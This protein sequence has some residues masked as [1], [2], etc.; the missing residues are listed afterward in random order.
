[1]AEAGLAANT[2]T[3][4]ILLKSCAATENVDE[5]RRLAA[6]MAEA[7]IEL[8]PNCAECYVPLLARS[9]GVGAGE[10]RAAYDSI[11]GKPTLKLVNEVMRHLASRGMEE[12]TIEYFS[13]MSRH[14]LDPTCA[15]FEPLVE[16]FCRK[17][18]MHRVHVLFQELRRRGIK[19]S[20]KVYHDVLRA[21]ARLGT[22]SPLM[23]HYWGELFKDK[24]TH[25]HT[26]ST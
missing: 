24:V 4:S 13:D 22:D 15:S 21:S 3:F 25:T 20:T 5:A 2:W 10:I 12:E 14:D 1:M 23:M 7:S 19:P 11:K 17:S 26:H 18:E 16:V 6:I 9:R 8:D